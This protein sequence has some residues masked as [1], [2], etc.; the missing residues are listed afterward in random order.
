M[1]RP[2]NLEVIPNKKE[3]DSENT[4][5]KD[6]LKY[7]ENRIK[8]THAVQPKFKYWGISDLNKIPFN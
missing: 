4:L 8:F 6:I 2:K 3:T 1:L 7:E 5:E